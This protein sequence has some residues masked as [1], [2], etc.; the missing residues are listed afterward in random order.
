MLR[1]AWERYRRP[2]VVAETGAQGEARGPWLAH[3]GDEVR[4]AQ[5][6]GIPILGVCLYPVLDYPGW[7]DDR[8]CEVG[9]W[10][11]ADETGGR[12]LYRPLA[13]ELRRQQQLT[14]YAPISDMD[15]DTDTHAGPAGL[16]WEESELATFP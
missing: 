4:A 13:E 7:D 9:L 16:S 6:A 12:P 2:L 8:H 10:G 11:Y 5:R 14:T 15:T 3:I 1:E